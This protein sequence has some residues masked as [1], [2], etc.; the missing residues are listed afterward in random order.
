MPG[1]RG[2]NFFTTLSSI[3][4]S[5]CAP[6]G[7]RNEKREEYL[8]SVVVGDGRGSFSNAKEVAK[9]RILI[10]K[11]KKISLILC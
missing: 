11:I 3:S 7:G 5:V 6:I 4:G 8:F 1:R 10:L 2:R 9:A